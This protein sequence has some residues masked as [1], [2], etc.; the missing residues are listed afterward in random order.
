MNNLIK[1]IK[2][3]EE[4]HDHE[5]I[6]QLIEEQLQRNSNDISLWLSLA[7]TIFAPPIVDYEKGLACLERVFEIDCNNVLGLLIQAYVYETQL[8]G[9]DDALLRKIQHLN[10]DS[11][12]LNSM[13][14][15]VASWSYS[16][17][18]KNDPLQQENLLKESI[19]LCNRHVW[20]YVHLARLYLKQNR[21]REARY[22]VSKALDNVE[23]EYNEINID[24]YDVTNVDHFINAHI[25][26]THITTENVTS[27]QKLESY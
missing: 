21:K 15:Y 22:L 27:I 13:L 8:G 24:D 14:K 7:I 12:E 19:K 5:K 11:D 3:L 17:N 26:G 6:Y 9:I 1:Q 10:A 4:N 16:W 20:N 23:Q 18:K 2:Y 25:K